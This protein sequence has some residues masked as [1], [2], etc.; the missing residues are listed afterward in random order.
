M[1]KLQAIRNFDATAIDEDTPRE[2]WVQA[3]YIVA[4]EE[5]GR[6][7]YSVHLLNAKES[8]LT[9]WEDGET[10]AR[11]MRHADNFWSKYEVPI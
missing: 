5:T 8:P 9:V 1:I 4:V 7:G 11:L 10:I 6:V 2:V 3:K